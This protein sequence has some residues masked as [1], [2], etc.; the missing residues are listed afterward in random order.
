MA[1]MIYVLILLYSP[2]RTGVFERLQH[3]PGFVI[4]VGKTEVVAYD[5]WDPTLFFSLGWAYPLCV[6]LNFKFQKIKTKKKF[7]TFRVFEF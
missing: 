6:N 2:L 5:I 3:F 7:R 1:S 4:N